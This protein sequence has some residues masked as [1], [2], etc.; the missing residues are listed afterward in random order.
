MRGRRKSGGDDGGAG[1]GREMRER[2]GGDVGEEAGGGSRRIRRGRRIGRTKEQEVDIM[3]ASQL[4][5]TEERGG[6]G[7][8]RGE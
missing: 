8:E 7:E 1:R 5:R 4:G 3:N 2:K 6:G